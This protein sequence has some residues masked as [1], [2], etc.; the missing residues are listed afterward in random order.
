MPKQVPLATVGNISTVYKYAI[1]TVLI[2]VTLPNRSII[3]FVKS[4]NK[5]L[6][7]H[8]EFDKDAKLLFMHAYTLVKNQLINLIPR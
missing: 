2:T 4:K 7:S 1:E 3:V 6:M 5:N 8:K